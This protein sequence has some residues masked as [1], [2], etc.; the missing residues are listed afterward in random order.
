MGFPLQAFA[1][2]VGDAQ[3]CH[4]QLTALK[5][6]LTA[7]TLLAVA[8]AAALAKDESQLART[9]GAIALT[10]C[11]QHLG[12]P[13]SVDQLANSMPNAGDYASLIDLAVAAR[14]HGFAARGVRWD[15][16]I[17]RGCSPAIVPLVAD[18][19]RQHFVAVLESLG[20]RVF[21][22]DG[23]QDRWVSTGELRT[24]GWDGTA[25]LVTRNAASIPGEGGMPQALYWISATLFTLA[26]LIVWRSARGD[27]R[28]SI[29]T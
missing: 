29:P 26:G 22:R 24:H 20:D 4:P 5:R 12:T 11:M 14:R 3:R 16:D 7:L 28:K 8:R 27:K 15:G 18:G 21:V 2:K 9:C 13:A 6:I 10:A 1:P 25:L 17:P 23:K 19:N